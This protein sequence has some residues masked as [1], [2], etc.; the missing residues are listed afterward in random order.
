MIAFQL[1]AAFMDMAQRVHSLI[2]AAL[3]FLLLFAVLSSSHKT[4]KYDWNFLQLHQADQQEDQ[5][6]ATGM[7]C[8]SVLGTSLPHSPDISQSAIHTA[9]WL[10]NL[11]C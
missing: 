11:W 1:H 5:Q 9:C 2:I 3:S 10:H 8:A 7:C 6:A 4:A